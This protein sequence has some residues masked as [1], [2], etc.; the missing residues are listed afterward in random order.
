MIRIQ[1]SSKIE[2]RSST[3]HHLRV[4]DFGGG[5]RTPLRFKKL[6]ILPRISCA[7]YPAIAMLCNGEYRWQQNSIGGHWK[8]KVLT[9]FFNFLS[10]TQRRGG[11]LSLCFP[12]ME[13]FRRNSSYKKIS[14]PAFRYIFFLTFHTYITHTKTHSSSICIK[15][16]FF[17]QT[18][19]LCS[20]LSYQ[21]ALHT[22]DI[23]KL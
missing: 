2:H 20:N 8:K 1:T 13:S 17:L 6:G 23:K 18:L 19:A 5:R 12:N 3:L 22:L 14:R 21:H 4:Q 11:V 16:N 15:W 7:A 10:M 9:S